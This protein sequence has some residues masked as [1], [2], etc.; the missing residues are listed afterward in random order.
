[1]LNFNTGTPIFI[2]RK[3]GD[4]KGKNDKIVYV[5]DK[6]ISDGFES[7]EPKSDEEFVLIPRKGVE[8]DILYT[9]GQGGSGKSY[10]TAQYIKE[11]HKMYPKNGIYLFSLV[12][13]DPS[14]NKKYIKRIDLNKLL[15]T[16][17]M[18][19]DLKNTLICYDD[20]D[21]VRDR[22]LRDKLVRLAN[23]IMEMGRH[24]QITFCYLS[25][26]SCKGHQTRT[27]L[28]EASHITIFPKFCNFNNLKY[29]MYN[30]VGLTKEQ[31][32]DILKLNGRSITYIKVFPPVL[33]SKEKAWV[34]KPKL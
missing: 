8:R 32:Q 13:D 26:L 5:T 34:L 11:Y 19:E 28:N 16:G 27:I 3:K 18:L 22:N 7:I 12:Q 6:D 31:L 24:H 30:Y 20:I 25:H 14:I 2:I 21:C 33:F 1:M 10:H 23:S 15:E 9:S 17:L 4:D 29:L